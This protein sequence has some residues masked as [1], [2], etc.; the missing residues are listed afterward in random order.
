MNI[1]NEARWTGLI[2]N[3]RTTRGDN[4]SVPRRD[5]THMCVRHTVYNS[6]FS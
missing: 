6:R 1:V 5:T 2:A 3:P 4:E